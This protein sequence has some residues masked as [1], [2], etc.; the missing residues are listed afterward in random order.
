MMRFLKKGVM[1]MKK[2]SAK[3]EKTNVQTV[4]LMGLFTAVICL[5][6]MFLKLPVP[7]MT[8]GYINFGDGFIIIISVM[9]GRKYGAVSGAAGSA[10]ADILLGSPHWALFTFIIK[11]AMGYVTGSVKDYSGENSKFFTVRNVSAAVICEVIMLGGYF[12]CGILLKGYFMTP[13][14]ARFL[15]SGATSLFEYGVIQASSS[16]FQ[17]LIQAVGSVVIFYFLGFALHNAKIARLNK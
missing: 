11:G 16:F 10:L 4:C 7:T 6:T 3:T 2:T 1:F 14:S 8:D 13:D 17:N 9:F 15:Q 12:V 5:G